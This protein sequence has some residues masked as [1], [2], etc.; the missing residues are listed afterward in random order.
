MIDYIEVAFSKKHR[1]SKTLY[2]QSKACI[3]E[4]SVPTYFSACRAYTPFPHPISS[5]PCT[6]STLQFI[7][8]R[9]TWPRGNFPDS[10]RQAARP[11]VFVSPA[12][13]TEIERF[14]V[15]FC[16]IPESECEVLRIPDELPIQ[17]VK[18]ENHEAWRVIAIVMQ[19]WE[20]L[21]FVTQLHYTEQRLSMERGARE[22]YLTI[23]SSVHYL[24]CTS[25]IRSDDLLGRK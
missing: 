6:A 21:G 2:L 20:A 19:M 25:K 13:H 11:V 23:F 18:G 3:L 14:L 22:Q 15:L 12:S 5:P 24:N 4:F 17:S 9:A 1:I 10:V 8:W 7:H 16:G